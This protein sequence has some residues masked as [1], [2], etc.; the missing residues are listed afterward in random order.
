MPQGKS[1]Q[2]PY[3]TGICCLLDRSG[4]IR[5]NR[6]VHR[7]GSAPLFG[8][9]CPGTSCYRPGPGRRSWRTSAGA[10]LPSPAAGYHLLSIGPVGYRAVS[11][12]AWTVRS[13]MGGKVASMRPGERVPHAQGAAFHVAGLAYGADLPYDISFLYSG[14]MTLCPVLSFGTASGSVLAEA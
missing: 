1:C 6:M 2:I 8:T 5:P 4:W 7:G 13:R 10:W 3:G 12:D 14:F 11:R 9:A